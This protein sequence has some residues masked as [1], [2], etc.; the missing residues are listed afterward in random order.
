MRAFHMLAL[1]LLVKYTTSDNTCV[2]QTM[3][4]AN[5]A[6]CNT[7]MFKAKSVNA[8]ECAA[9][10]LCLSFA[11]C[12]CITR[13][14]KLKPRDLAMQCVTNQQCRAKPECQAPTPTPKAK[15]GWTRWYNRDRPT[16]GADAENIEFE[17]PHPCEGETP[18]DVRCVRVSN[19][20][21]ANETLA[22]ETKQVFSRP[23]GL[24]GLFC[25]NK[26]NP[27]GCADYK[28]R[29]L[30]P[31]QPVFTCHSVGDPHIQKFDGD[32][33]DTHF[34][35]WMPLYSKGNFEIELH[36]VSWDKNRPFPKGPAVNAAIRYRTD[37]TKKWETRKDGDLLGPNNDQ[38]GVWR[39]SNPDVTVTVKSP[40]YLTL[41]W[42]TVKRIY[43][44]WVSTKD[45]DGAKGQCI[46]GVLKRRLL[47]TS[48]GV[49]FPSN[50]NV[51]KVQAQ[52]ACAG[53]GSQFDNCIT[54]VRMADDPAASA[55]IAKA[56][57][58]VEIT[59]KQV[60]RDAHARR[61]TTVPT[62]TM[63]VPNSTTSVPTPM[64]TSL[65]TSSVDA[66]EAMSAVACLLVAVAV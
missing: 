60:E 30:C 64:A 34:E 6:T 43:N 8:H 40:N 15:P 57:V 29:Y 47:E 31:H 20:M 44:V 65:Q 55:T 3:S 50:P 49:S 1:A 48:G 2:S 26:D 7:I 5:D 45:I 12:N 27:A 54:D 35:G 28:V 39:F 63:T 11:E 16:G 42:A 38:S 25:L 59:Q 51:T 61:T 62:P 19:G 14:L 23:C 21:P 56:F 4:C 22:N 10:K 18:L 53:L 9:N 41:G 32:I 66:L 13:I 24:Q 46:E 58:E 17:D 33:F 36:Q 52:A 37:P